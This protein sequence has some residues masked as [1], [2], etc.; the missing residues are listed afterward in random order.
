MN[1]HGIPVGIHYLS[2]SHQNHSLWKS[3]SFFTTPMAS[4]F[5]ENTDGGKEWGNSGDFSSIWSSCSGKLV[6]WKC[7]NIHITHCKYSGMS[8]SS[9]LQV[10]HLWVSSVIILYQLLLGV[11]FG[12]V[13]L[14][15]RRNQA[16]PLLAAANACFLSLQPEQTFPRP[17]PL[18]F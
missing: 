5:L 14:A 7:L 13:T 1:M 6:S 15:D 12:M 10:I 16:V 4:H 18:F 2:P 8:A 17:A 9:C 3:S 11:T